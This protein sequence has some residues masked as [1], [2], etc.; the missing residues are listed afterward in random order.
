[1]SATYPFVKI[2][3]SLT[4]FFATFSL[5]K[6]YQ[7][8][9]CLV[10]EYITRFFEMVITLIL[11][12]IIG[13]ASSYTT[14]ISLRV[15]FIHINWVQQD[16]AAMYSTS[17]TDKDIESYFLLN[18]ETNLSPKKNSPPLLVFLSPILLTQSASLY[19]FNMKSPLFLYQRP[20]FELPFKNLKFLFTSCSCDCFRLSWNILNN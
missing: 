5:T 9:I 12:Y 8:E 7:F 3:S 17:A 1:M 4:S 16:V 18:Q 11:S 14:L 19:A 6:W 2:Y 10:L 13:I 15:Y 20:K